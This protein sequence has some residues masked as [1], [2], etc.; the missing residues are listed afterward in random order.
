[1]NTIIILLSI[2]AV[3]AVL[4]AILSIHFCFETSRAIKQFVNLIK[5]DE[6]VNR[7]IAE[8]WSGWDYI[9]CHIRDTYLDK[10]EP[11]Y[12]RYVSRG[13]CQDSIKGREMFFNSLMNKVKKSRVSK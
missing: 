4:A 5:D 12:K 1:M 2:S 9:R 11:V 7:F 10:L 13:L 8:G 6:F 3:A